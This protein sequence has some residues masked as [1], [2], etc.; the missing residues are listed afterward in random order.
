MPAGRPA[1]PIYTLPAKEAASE[2]A[3]S[4]PVACERYLGGI[5]KSLFY[6]LVEAGEIEVV[7]EGRRTIVPVR[8]LIDRLAAKI[9]EARRESG[10]SRSELA[11][12]RF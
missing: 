11:W 4:I 12:C 6:E 9:D 7:H 10:G 3:V 5:K 2:G 1:K 8:Q